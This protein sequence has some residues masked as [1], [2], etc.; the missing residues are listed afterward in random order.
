M[1]SKF[2]ASSRNSSFA[3]LGVGIV[4]W[5]ALDLLCAKE[6][7]LIDVVEVEPE[8]FW[9]PLPA[10]QGFR[11]YLGEVLRHLAHPKILHGVGGSLAGTCGPPKGHAATLAQDV[12]VLRPAYVSE[13]L[14]FSRFN[15][16]PQRSPASTSFMLPPLQTSHGVIQAVENISRYRASLGDVPVA[17]ET[18][19]SYLPLCPGHL[20]DGEFLAE[21]VRRADC[22]ILLDLHNVLC[23]ARNGRQ[24]VRDFCESIPLERVWEIHWAGGELERGVYIDSHSGLAD[25]ELIEITTDLMPHLPNLRAL[26]FEIMPERVPQLGLMAIARQIEVLRDLWDARDPQHSAAQLRP[27]QESQPTHSASSMSLEQWESLLAGAVLDLP[28]PAVEPSIETWWQRSARAIDLY[29]MLSA[30]ARASAIAGAAPSVT[31]TLLESRGVKETREILTAFWGVSLPNFTAT[32][33]AWAFTEY[34]GSLDL[35]IEGLA[36]A[37]QSDRVLLAMATN[38]TSL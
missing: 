12:E 16:R 20:S 31:R 3:P 30:D 15:A 8:A 10:G 28:T 27:S 21:I 25:P 32:D 13:H 19:V 34:L 24:S 22:G 26:V 36:A 14:N 7:G 38:Q 17:V 33:E 1:N 37:I 35:D 18:P 6:D 29:K 2:K 5:P 9:S 23:N 11:S 4:W